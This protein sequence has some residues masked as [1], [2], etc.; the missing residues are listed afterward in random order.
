M[1]HTQVFAN[2]PSKM[3]VDF[4]TKYKAGYGDKFGLTVFTYSNRDIEWDSS[5]V[6]RYAKT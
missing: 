2:V 6:E 3:I 1:A 4:L 5:L